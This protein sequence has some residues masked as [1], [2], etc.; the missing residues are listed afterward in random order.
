LIRSLFNQLQTYTDCIK[1]GICHHAKAGYRLWLLSSALLICFSDVT[2][3]THTQSVIILHQQG[4]GFSQQLIQHLKKDITARGIRVETQL[5]TDKKPE[6]SVIAHHN[7]IIALGS[8]TTKILLDSKIEQPVLSLLIPENLAIALDLHYP[9]KKMWSSLLID[10]PIIRHF[11][12]STALLGKHASLGIILGPLT[13]ALKNSFQ[14]AANKT[15][16]KL[17]VHSI[18]SADQLAR[19]LQQMSQKV[20]VLLTSPDPE[21]YNKNT[22]RSILL[23]SYRYK[24]PII[25]FSKAYVHAGAIAAIYSQPQQISQQAAKI[26]EQTL[27]T[28]QILKKRYQP[29]DFSVSLNQQVARSLGIKLPEVS[30]IIQHIKQLEAEQ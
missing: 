11:H 13:Q 12:L 26:I 21:L 22:I 14:T 23:S 16:H 7:L 29:D 1:N 5:L 18:D 30:R 10:Q 9:E 8:R 20:D 4:S 2:A 24:I 25:G 17:F 6:V 28:G 19:T 3:A 27:N 15:R